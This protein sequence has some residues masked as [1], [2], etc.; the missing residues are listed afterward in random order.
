MDAETWRRARALFDDLADLPPAQWAQR[1]DAL[2][3]D[4][5][6][7]A[8]VLAL[9]EADRVEMLHTAV[10]NQAPQMLA[11]LADADRDA[12]HQ[13]LAGQRVG[14][15]RLLREI[16][17]GGMGTVWLAE[18][19]EGGFVQNVAVKLIRPGWDAEEVLTRF[20]AERQ[21]L[22]GLTHPNI[23]RLIDGGVTGDGRPW[24]ALEYVDGVDLRQYCDRGHRDLVQRMSLF[25]T[26][27]DAVSHAHARLVVHRDLKPSNLLVTDAGEVKLLDFGIAKLIDANAAPISATRVFTPEYAA[28]EQV[29]GETVTTAV[30]VYAL[31]LLLYELLTGRRPYKVNNSTPAAY[32]RAILDQEPTRPSLAVTRDGDAADAQAIAAQRDLTPQRLRRELR[33][34][35]D[36]IVLK[37]LRKDPA[38]R[39]AS[40]ADL[41]ADVI[42]HLRQ[43][44]V[45]ARRGNWRYHAGRFLRRHALAVGFAAAAA[46][47]L[48]IGL[49]T[50]LWQ[51]HQAR[52]QRDAARHSLVFMTTLFHNADPGL[53]KRADLSVRDLLD[54]GVRAIRY[55]FGN[56]NTTRAELLLAMSDA[57]LG[58]DVPDPAR[59]LVDEAGRLAE[60]DGDALLR[61]QVLEMRCRLLLSDNHAEACL[62]LL[63]RIEAMLDSRDARH[64]ETIV[65]AIDARSHALAA[66]NRHAEI[67]AQSERALA[68]LTHAPEHRR[69]RE[70]IIGTLSYSLVK[71][72][73]SREA[74]AVLRDLLTE[75]RG[76]G[77]VPPRIVADTLDNLGAALM[78]QSRNDEALA[79]QRESLGLMEGLYG[80][81]SPV[82]T[83]KI[84]NLGVAL[85]AAG[86]LAEARPVIERAVALNRSGGEARARGLNNALGNLGALTLQLH[87]D[88]ASRRYLD[89]AI[90]LSERLAMPLDSGRSL[91]WRGILSLA[92]GRYAD[93]RGDL[94]HSLDLL[95]PLYPSGHVIPLRGR[96]MLLATAFAEHGPAAHTPTNCSEAALIDRTFA[97]SAEATKADAKLAHLLGQLCA[98]P[99]T[100]TQTRSDAFA[101]ID[102][103]LPGDDYRRRVVQRIIAAWS[104][105]P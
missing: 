98:T 47:A 100:D 72:N 92:Q 13:G 40:V 46:L 75:L 17:R 27:C 103:G 42:N 60:Q 68:L 38:Q 76:G 66:Q 31:G 89:E 51:G 85:Y 44:P 48:V 101:A 78:A 24:L 83:V 102:A 80:Q 81:D 59:P 82:I 10:E 65:H 69:Q 36:A 91:R 11:D 9:L 97:A 62:P 41:A 54:E 53:K 74:E 3:L 55:A 4:A 25:L 90:A 79:L 35:L 56:E 43:R 26:V 77:D 87:D 21:I 61:A 33:G 64:V 37:A 2:N 18:R 104:P 20:R 50:A 63:D 49:G 96:N 93:A 105:A 5:A 58:L 6:L 95:L 71:L 52:I 22:A 1:L 30:D 99:T 34:D 7:R 19:I 28:P 32:E 15:F 39:Y 14:A 8:E 45:S 23:A 70:E 84:D 67:V 86:K 94:Q 12:Q 29:R 73:R 16:G 88:D 57:Y